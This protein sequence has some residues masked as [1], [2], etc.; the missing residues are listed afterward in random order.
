MGCAP[1]CLGLAC[2]QLGSNLHLLQISNDMNHYSMLLNRGLL[3]SAGLDASSEVQQW[4]S[5]VDRLQPSTSA[6]EQG[7]GTPLPSDSDWG[8]PSTPERTDR[9]RSSGG[10]GRSVAAGI[11]K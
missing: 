9:G 4:F 2:A 8:A 7:R 3:P 11:G 10:N 6:F 5:F 1:G